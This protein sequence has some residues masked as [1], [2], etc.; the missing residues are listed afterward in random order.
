MRSGAM[1]APQLRRTEAKA[2]FGEACKS[3]LCCVH[4]IALSRSR[5][6]QLIFQRQI[7]DMLC[8][9]VP[10]TYSDIILARAQSAHEAG[11]FR[12]SVAETYC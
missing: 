5:A 7:E 9:F 8:T 1:S 2:F 4:A 11:K 6:A 12:T 10:C 3:A